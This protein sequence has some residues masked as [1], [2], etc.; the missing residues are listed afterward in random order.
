MPALKGTLRRR[1]RKCQSIELQCVGL[2]CPWPSAEAQTRSV[3][4]G[5]S[6]QLIRVLVFSLTPPLR[7]GMEEG[8]NV[9][10]SL[11][12]QVKCLP[13]LASILQS[14]VYSVLITGR[15]LSRRSARGT[16][17]QLCL[18]SPSYAVSAYFRKKRSVSCIYEH[19]ALG[20][21]RLPQDNRN[22]MPPPSCPN[23]VRMCAA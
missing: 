4:G 17:T 11:P 1:T 10:L 2:T 5:G 3:R 13:A 16:L 22:G 9:C 14:A 21:D 15:R 6:G 20:K 8:S 12:P 19:R 23:L 7:A 18:P